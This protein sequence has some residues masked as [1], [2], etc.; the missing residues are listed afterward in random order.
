[1]NKIEIHDHLN[2]LC[3]NNAFIANTLYVN[4]WLQFQKPFI[5]AD[6][7]LNRIILYDAYMA[8]SGECF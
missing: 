5:Q 6:D 8:G 4:T 2:L 1:M 3:A 7:V